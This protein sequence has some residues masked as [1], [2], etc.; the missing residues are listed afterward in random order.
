[1]SN[2]KSNY[3]YPKEKQ[4][5][6]ICPMHGDIGIL[7]PTTMEG[8]LNT[9]ELLSFTLDGDNKHF[10]L[11]CWRDYLSLHLPSLETELK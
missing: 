5:H 11:R 7:N 1:M 4:Q 6:L 3:L 8:T 10:C 2:T 9:A